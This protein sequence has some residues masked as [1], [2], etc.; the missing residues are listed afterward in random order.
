[1]E[2][3]EITEFGPPDVLRLT[4]RARPAPQD[5]E[6]LIKVAAS[7]VNRPDILQRLGKYPPPPGVT[8]IPG[9]EVSGIITQSRHP[10]WQE[11]DK[12]CALLPGGGYA[13]Y[14]AVPGDHCLKVPETL[15]LESAAGLPEAVFTVWNNLFVRGQLTAGQTALIHG[16]SSGIGT[17]AIQ[18]ARLCGARV[19]VTAGSAEKCAACRELG[20]ELA[21]NYKEDDFVE[22]VKDFTGGRGVDVVLDM[23]GGSYVPRNISALA[24]EGRHVSIAFLDGITA[25]INIAAIMQK[26]L[27]LTG[28]TLRPRPDS[29]K[30]ALA[31]G[32]KEHIWPFI[33]TRELKPVIYKNLPLSRAAEAHR[34]MEEGDHIGKI[35]LSAEKR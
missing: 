30:A 25:Q 26:R 31:A 4:E 7:G 16:G 2:A 24:P 34:I 33:E 22:S 15:D 27:T 23:V 10:Q 9:L 29:E 21:I 19:I 3:V 18:M 6:V 1:M 20:A 32:I 5:G 8:D 28:S 35:L 13:A 14:A 11:G 12:V 17:A